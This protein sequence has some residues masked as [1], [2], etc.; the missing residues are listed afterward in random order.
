MKCSDA[1]PLLDLLFDDAL[2]TKD[3]AL[4]LDHLKSCD[5]C[6]QEW[7]ELEQL[8]A[9]FQSTKVKPQLPAGLM[10]RISDKLKDEE[11]S[12]RKR[13][14]AQFAHTL[15]MV[16]IAATVA[17]IGLFLLSSIHQVDPRSALIQTASADTLVDDLGSERT[18]APVADRSELDSRVGYN[19]KYLRLPQWQMNRFGVYKSKTATPIA[20]FDF[21]RKDGSG[22]QHLSCYQ[23]P[24]GT[25]L[26][27][28]AYSENVEGKRVYFGN[29]GNLQYALWSQNGRDYL[30]VT[31]LSK[32]QLE[33]IVRGT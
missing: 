21:V 22:S 7:N 31:A 8:R 26:A 11:R 18:L 16:A 5:E 3:S 2:E 24:Q 6:Q 28:G 20:R 23:A 19:L 15:P 9:S 14:F 27:Q 1:R 10:T 13:Y 32:P 25:I 4:V 33:E 29:H 17:L 12:E 30:F